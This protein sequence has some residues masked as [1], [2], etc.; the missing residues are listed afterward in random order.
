MLLVS[1]PVVLFVIYYLKHTIPRD[2]F[3]KKT[4]TKSYRVTKG[5]LDNV[6]GPESACFDLLNQ[7][8]ISDF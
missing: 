7:R 6:R 3:G 5:P 8:C 1:D 2:L 4:K